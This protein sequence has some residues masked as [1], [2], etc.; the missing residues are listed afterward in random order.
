MFVD[1]A[2]TIKASELGGVK[3]PV[4][5]HIEEDMSHVRRIPLFQH[6][7]HIKTL[8]NKLCNFPILK[9][10]QCLLNRRVK[11]TAMILNKGFLGRPLAY[12]H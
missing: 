10:T 11:W 5:V 1:Y 4:E 9:T 2:S 7:R 6:L 3:I 12:P 8:R